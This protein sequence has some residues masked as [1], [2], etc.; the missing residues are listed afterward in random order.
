MGLV[1]EIDLRN[2]RFNRKL[3]KSGSRHGPIQVN[4][5]NQP[6]LRSCKSSAAAAFPPACLNLGTDDSNTI[7]PKASTRD[8][9]NMPFSLASEPRTKIGDED[10]LPTS[11]AEAAAV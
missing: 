7:T 1:G 3:R 5:P 4:F 9:D 8:L 6:S 2:E 11:V 10:S